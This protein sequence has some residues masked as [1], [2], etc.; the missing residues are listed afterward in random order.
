MIMP[1][2]EQCDILVIGGGPAGSTVS[3]L[4]S[5]KGWKVVLLEKD[6]HPRFHI[7]ESLLPKSLPIFDLLGVRSQVE[8]IGIVKRGAEFV[9]KYH[10]GKSVTYYF[11]GYFASR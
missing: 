5:E 1:N 3:T 8:K 4:L 7:G 6:H 2:M 9:S 11:K 10:E